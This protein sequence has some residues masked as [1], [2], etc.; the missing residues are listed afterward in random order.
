MTD[1]RIRG[2]WMTDGC[3]DN[4]NRQRWLD[5]RVCGDIAFDYEPGFDITLEPFVLT[6]DDRLEAWGAGVSFSPDPGE[7]DRIGRDKFKTTR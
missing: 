5:V 4:L 7:I 3:I 1:Y 6:S 2:D